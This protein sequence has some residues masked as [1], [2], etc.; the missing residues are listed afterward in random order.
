MIERSLQLAGNSRV[1]RVDGK[2]GDV[3]IRR[4]MSRELE[5]RVVNGQVSEFLGVI[6]APE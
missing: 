5:L 3:R 6:L 4:T 1:V 2:K